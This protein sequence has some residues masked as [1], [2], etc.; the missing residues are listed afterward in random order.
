VSCL[1]CDKKFTYED[2]I[3]YYPKG[4]IQYKKDLKQF[5]EG[6]RYNASLEVTELQQIIETV[7]DQYQK[8][9]DSFAKKSST[10]KW[11]DFSK[12]WLSNQEE[13][14]N[15]FSQLKNSDLREK[16]YFLD[17]YEELQTVVR[18]LFE[19]HMIQDA[20]KNKKTDYKKYD[21]ITSDIEKSISKFKSKLDIAKLKLNKSEFI[22]GR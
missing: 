2:K 11:E 10:Q 3:E 6:V 17:L 1:S 9:K 8:T 19:M 5:N 18:G 7:K 4:K 16:I 22:S 12:Q 14:I 15:L 20:I 13:L 21:K